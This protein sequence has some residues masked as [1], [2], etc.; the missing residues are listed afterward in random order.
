[1]T[2]PANLGSFVRELVIKQVVEETAD[3]KSLVFDIPQGQEDD[4]TYTPGQFLTLRIPSELTGSVARC[5]SLSSSPHSDSQL[6]VAIKRTKDGYA[7]NWICDNATEGMSM[8]VL[9]PS[10]TFTPSNLDDDFLLCAGGSGITPM[11]SILKSALSQGSGKITLFYANRGEADVIYAQQIQQL[12]ADHT[13]RFTLISWLETHKGLPTVEKLA[14]EFSPIASGRKAFICGPGPFMTATK[15]ALLAA[16]MPEAAINIEEFYSIEG[17]PFEEVSLNVSAE[18]LADAATAI[19]HLDDETHEVSWPRNAN[20]LDVLLDKGI[21]APFSCKKG[22]CSACACIVKSGDT[23]MTY[24]GIL[25]PD[26]I[27]EGFTLSCQTIPKSDRVEITF[28]E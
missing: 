27:E 15:E 14:E 16:G 2:T 5:Y 18:D 1:M 9:S 12:A 19:V 22:D 11:L 23:E 25:E 6:V 26:E 20:L 3:A 13:D 17:D 21:K 7:S 4:F 24:N 28:N 10:G 8:H